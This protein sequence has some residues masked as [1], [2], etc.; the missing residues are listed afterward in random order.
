QLLDYIRETSVLGSIGAL[1][2]WDQETQ[3]PPKGADHRAKQMS[4]IARMVHERNTA[5]QLGELL[6]AVESSS[7][8][9]DAESDAAVIARETRRAFDRATK[10]PA[11]LVEEMARTA[12]LAHQAWAKA[13]K[14]SDFKQFQPWLQKTLDLKRQEADCVGHS[15]E[16][17]DAL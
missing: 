14:D 6:Q 9:H 4:L 8:V 11:S 2:G 12:V 17:Y 5:P 1:L 3:M 13:R 10:L 15:G 16:R 7:L